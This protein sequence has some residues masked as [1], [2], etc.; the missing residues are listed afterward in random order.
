MP[1]V[2]TKYRLLIFRRH[3]PIL[4]SARSIF[5]KFRK[6]PATNQQIPE[7]FV[8]GREILG[9]SLVR[10][11]IPRLDVRTIYRHSF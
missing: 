1:D 7:K 5:A 2:C 4:I 10:I 6:D 11:Y 3:F 9:C 8:A